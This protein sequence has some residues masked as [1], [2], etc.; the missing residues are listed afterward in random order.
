MQQSYRPLHQLWA[1]GIVA[2][3][4]RRVDTVIK[5][6]VHFEDDMTAEAVA[7]NL[8][9]FVKQSDAIAII[10]ADR[11]LVSQAI[12]ES[13]A[14]SVPIVAYV[15]DLS[16]AS[17]AGFVGTDNWKAGRTAGRLIRQMVREPG[18][19]CPLIAVT[20]ISAMIF[21]PRVSAPTCA[22]MPGSVKHATR[23]FSKSSQTLTEPSAN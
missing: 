14:T 16:A 2:A 17:R 13:E 12:D 21:Q 11:P 8:L 9:T 5:A 7:S 19:V 1:T 4:S 22:S 23:S 18:K 6:N 15:A 20:A 10:C 3:A